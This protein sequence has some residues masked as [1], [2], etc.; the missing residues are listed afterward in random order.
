MTETDMTLLILFNVI[1]SIAGVCALAWFALWAVR[2]A[3]D[4]A[5]ELVQA[6]D[7]LRLGVWIYM[8]CRARQKVRP[9]DIGT[10]EV[11][12]PTERMR[13]AC[14]QIIELA[15]ETGQVVT[16]STV[17]VPGSPPAIGNYRMEY[18]VRP[19]RIDGKYGAPSP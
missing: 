12:D 17:P 14:A 10:Y 7:R 6:Y 2:A 13:R 16:I 11:L 18:N 3:G 5:H 9:L 4:W 8:A 15:R 19:A 1:G